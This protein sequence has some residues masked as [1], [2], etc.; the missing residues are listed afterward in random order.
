MK[1]FIFFLTI[2]FNVL[3]Y[4]EDHSAIALMYHR[5]NEPEYQSTSISSEIFEKH[6]KHIK[7][8][9]FKVFTSTLGTSRWKNMEQINGCGVRAAAQ[10]TDLTYWTH[11]W[12]KGGG[13]KEGAQSRGHKV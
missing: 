2:F 5:F 9:G 13:A 4:A 6:L 10:Y 11:N 12:R 1:K 8:N 3:C 7:E